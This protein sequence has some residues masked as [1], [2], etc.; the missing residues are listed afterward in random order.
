LPGERSRIDPPGLGPKQR[1]AT[2]ECGDRLCCKFVPI[3]LWGSLVVATRRSVED[4]HHVAEALP[5][6]PVPGRGGEGPANA[7]PD[8]GQ[9]D[10]G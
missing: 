1:R 6:H 9:G 4:P 2:K 3:N 10:R 7:Q 5:D 8:G